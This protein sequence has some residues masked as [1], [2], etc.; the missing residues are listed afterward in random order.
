MASRR[1]VLPV[2]GLF[3]HLGCGDDALPG[4]DPDATCQA[5]STG[6]SGSDGDST[7][8]DDA[9]ATVA[10]TG[11]DSTGAG[12]HTT[13]GTSGGNTD[14]TLATGASTSEGS[15]T[16]GTPDDADYRAV[17]IVGGLD[18]IRIF[19]HDLV[20]DHCTWITLVAPSLPSRFDVTT[21]EGWSVESIAIS[22][23]GDACDSDTPD[24]FGAETAT[25]AMGAIEFG[26]PGVVYPCLV[27]PDVEAA[28]AGVLPG[29]P[30]T[31]DV[32]ASDIPV[33][34]VE[35]C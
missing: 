9:D 4:C 19:K 5:P 31:D 11:G 18:R 29:I 14:A 21:P 1:H 12:D 7:A 34:G 8:G 15:E 32:V 35:G 3:V 33:E 17:A 27:S 22:D 26:N 25:S 20:A 23:M 28:F 2:L 6:G 13:S 10:S 24:M 30:P 16:T